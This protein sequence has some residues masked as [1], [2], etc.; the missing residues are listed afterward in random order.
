MGDLSLIEINDLTNASSVT[1]GT[2]QLAAWNELS[3]PSPLALSAALDGSSTNVAISGPS[4]L[5]SGSLL[6]VGSEVLTVISSA[7]GGSGFVVDRA[8]L[9]S[10]A[11]THLLGDPV[12]LLTQTTVVVPFAAGFFKNRAS[13]NYLHTINLPDARIC[14]AE[15]YVTNSFGNSQANQICYLSS[16]QNGLRT[17]SGGQFCFQ[18]SGFVTTQQSAAPPFVVE[19]AHAVRDVRANLT[20]ASVGYTVG[21][22]L[23]Q[24]GTPYCS[25]EIDSGNT[26]CRAIID[27]LSLVPLAEGATLAINVSVIPTQGFTGA[28][29][30]GRDLTVTVRL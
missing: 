28:A 3:A 29:S 27:G 12:L 20:Q 17:L 8:T 22:E 16:T 18:V 5:P 6:L 14:A 11:T 4:N 23:L 15:F 25:L 10:N 24:N 13:Q 26:S 7:V 19:A 9:S 21:I 2:L 1:T 30:V